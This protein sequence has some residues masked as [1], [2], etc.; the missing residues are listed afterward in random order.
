MFA[1]L[2]VPSGMRDSNVSNSLDTGRRER[3]GMK[4]ASPG[5]CGL[6]RLPAKI[7]ASVG[8]IRTSRPNNLMASLR[9]LARRV[10]FRVDIQQRERCRSGMDPEEIGEPCWTRTSDP[11]LKR[12]RR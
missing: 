3:L 2:Q 10:V 8:K 12:Q 7:S 4:D 5:F 9:V 6:R 1:K 11:L